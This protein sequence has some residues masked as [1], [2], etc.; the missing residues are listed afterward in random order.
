MIE[1]LQNFINTYYIEPI[2]Y[3]TG[4]NIFNTLTYGIIFALVIY[5]IYKL[6]KKYDVKIDMHFIIGVIP[7][8]FLASV[9]HVL[10]DAA[11][12]HTYLFIT[13]LLPMIVFALTLGL[14]WFSKKLKKYTKQDY[15]KT[16]GL[17]GTALVLISLIPFEF[18]NFYGGGII[19]GIFL[20]FVIGITG[21]KKLTRL[22][23]SYFLS[24]INLS[25]L[26]A[27]IFDA[28]T[29]FATLQFFPKYTEQ[30]VLANFFID[31]LGPIGMY[32]L[33]IPVIL[34]VIYLLGRKETEETT[35]V[36]LAIIILGLGPGFRNLLRLIV[37]V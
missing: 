34:L 3:K 28:T 4:Y 18:T 36:K 1:A 25:V 26:Y 2:I 35:F 22:K 29:T 10:E 33:K 31:I 21:I 16:W 17:F 6:L 13:P 14:L 8:I 11:I 19:L 24:N 30:H 27:H 12:I 20:I 9:W 5:G 15:W 23:D 7:Y 32:V 37:G